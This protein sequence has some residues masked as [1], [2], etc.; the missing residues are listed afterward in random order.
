M[1]RQARILRLRNAMREANL[2]GVAL[3]PGTGL[4]Y[5]SGIHTHMSERPT[6][7]FLPAEGDPAIVIPHLEAMKAEA[8]GIPPGRIFGWS[9]EEGY[10]GAFARAAEALSL[11]GSRYAVEALKMRVLEF[12]MLHELGGRP[13]SHADE[14]LKQIRLSKDAH[15]LA[16]MQAAVDVAESA[17]QTV[18]PLI[19]IG[20][21]E[22][23]IAGLLLVALLEAGAE[24]LPFS[25][26]VSTGVNGASPHAVPTDNR[27]QEG[28]LLIIDWGAQVGDYVSDITRTFAVGYISDELRQVYEIVRQANAAGMA[29]CRPGVTGEAID[30]AARDVIDAAGYGAF[31]IHRTGHGL[32]MEAHEPPSL[33]AGERQPLPAGA[34]FTVEPGIYLPGKGGVRIEDDIVLTEDG[35]RSLTS[36]PRE[37]QTVG[38]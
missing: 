4:T 20:Q 26:I 34:V 35:Y 17:I 21:T 32:G 37:L 2:D 33:V 38:E 25:P 16:Q 6:V 12:E 15:E 27:L 22:K 9:D 36:L 29:V 10:G 3:V 8:A 7:L 11:S 23:E 28:D 14:L 30:R 18:L 19:R 31:F 13:P 5:F 1:L 24:Q